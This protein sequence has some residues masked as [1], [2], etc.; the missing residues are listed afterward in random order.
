MEERKTCRTCQQSKPTDQFHR[1]KYTKD[2]LNSYCKECNNQKSKDWHRNNRER[3]LAA[4]RQWREE[5]RERATAISKAW[6]ERN[7]EKVL[8]YQRKYRE[9]DPE[10]YRAG[11]T[12]HARKKNG[13]TPEIVEAR[14]QAQQGRCPICQCELGNSFHA[15]HD[16]A[17]GAPRGLLC[18][19]CNH[20]LGRFRDSISNLQAA[21]KYLERHS[22]P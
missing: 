19:Y 12:A 13:F 21:I 18:Q 8:N 15:D 4:N 2:G 7:P 22:K 14:Y 1:N 17:T 3:S 20:G 11:R 5:N 10:A 9:R 6:K 16:H